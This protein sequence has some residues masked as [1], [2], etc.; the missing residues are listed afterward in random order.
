MRGCSPPTLHH[1]KGV[2]DLRL[3]QVDAHDGGQVLHAHLVDGR[4]ALHL[5]QEA[6]KKKQE[7]QRV[8]NFLLVPPPPALLSHCRLTDRYS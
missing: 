6:A 5:K 1:G 8:T 3:E 7:T 4:V 2:F